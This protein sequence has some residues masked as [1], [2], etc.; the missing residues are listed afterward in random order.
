MTYVEGGEPGATGDTTYPD[1]PVTQPAGDTLLSTALRMSRNPEQLLYPREEPTGFDIYA[2]KD[3]IIREDL[4]AAEARREG[5]TPESIRRFMGS[6]GEAQVPAEPGSTRMGFNEDT[7]AERDIE[8]FRRNRAQKGA[9]LKA[10]GEMVPGLP[11]GPDAFCIEPYLKVSGRVGRSLI[12]SLWFLSNS[13]LSLF[14]NLLQT[15]LRLE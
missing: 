1:I 2:E 9:P 12:L 5:P 7:A 4:A 14:Q 15:C 10:R 3:R 13:R 8:S 6:S 11:E